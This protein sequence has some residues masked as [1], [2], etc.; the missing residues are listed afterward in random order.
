MTV[1]APG[2]VFVVCVVGYG[3]LTVVGAASAWDDAFGLARASGAGAEVT[4][5]NDRAD[6]D[7]RF[8][9]VFRPTHFV[10]VS[11]RPML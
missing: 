10:Q 9:S 1:R 7:R 6:G 2:E 5:E 11:R 8:D 3:E 4:T